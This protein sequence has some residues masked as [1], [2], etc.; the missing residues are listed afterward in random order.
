MLTQKRKTSRNQG[1]T[2]IELLVVVAIIALLISIL[3]PSLKRA[4]DQAKA[5][6][7]L[8]HQKTLYNGATLYGADNKNYLPRGIQGLGSQTGPGEYQVFASAVLPYVGWN[9]KGVL[10]V[11]RPGYHP[12]QVRRRLNDT[13]RQFPMFQDPAYPAWYDG[14][15]EHAS[16]QPGTNPQHFVTSTFPTPYTYKNIDYDAGN[17]EWREDAAWVPANAAAADYIGT[18]RIEKFPAEAP[19]SRVIY[20]TAVDKTVPWSARRW[21]MRFYSMFLTSHLPFG[22]HP[23]IDDLPRHPNGHNCLFFDGHAKIL[24]LKQIDKSYPNPLDE[25]LKWFTVMPDGW[26]P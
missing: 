25:R 13:V 18:S 5:T 3:L 1:F 21:G 7:C 16:K 14:M 2:L 8:T 9:E 26:T 10:W 19:P 24:D 15:D 22:G 17:L 23:R 6:V 20:M 12:Q 11:S 4:K